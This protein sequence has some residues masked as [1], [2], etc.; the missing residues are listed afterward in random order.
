MRV[1]NGSA[2]V[3][4]RTAI[5]AL[6]LVLFTYGTVAAQYSFE[7]V[8]SGL[9]HQN[10]ATRLRAIEILTD[11]DYPE[12]AAPIAATL[13]DPDDRVQLAAIAAERAL[14]TTRPVARRK[15][16]GYIIE[17]RTADAGSQAFAAQLAL[18]PRRVPPEV[19]RGLAAAIK[20][21]NPRVGLEAMNAF[22][23]LAPLAG[24]DASAEIRSGIIW[25]LEALRRG[26]RAFQLAAAAVSGQAMQN[27][28]SAN[29]EAS[30]AL[31]AASLCADVG[32][33]LIETVNS[34]D[35]QLRRA[36]MH[37]LGQLRYSYAAQ[38]LAD[39]FS[40][41]Q[42]GPDAEAALEGLAGTGDVASA[43][44]FQSLLTSSSTVVRRLAVEGLARAGSREDLAELQRMG[45]SERSNAVLLALHY[46]TLT[47]ETE[48]R[49]TAPFSAVQALVSALQDATLRPL[50]LQYLLD[51]SPTIASALAEAL[52]DPDADTRRLTADVL[53][54]SG[55]RTL[56]PALEAATKDRDADVALAARRAIDRIQLR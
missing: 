16:I 22:G 42:R 23:V 43:P 6:A 12:A 3:Q 14:F 45:Q 32:K 54:F 33:V 15:K 20:D 31:G 52:R 2:I 48:K 13:E 4:R 29:P 38:A 8:A 55:D 30:G 26:T 7:E 1:N 39:Q 49:G 5:G 19:F 41:Y 28:G 56:I 51:L 21:E 44:I 17:V 50:A 24:P 40:H 10:P 46:A 47:L 27:C 34:R 9:Q 18:L 25:T 36:A 35:P 11:A 53:G 37:A